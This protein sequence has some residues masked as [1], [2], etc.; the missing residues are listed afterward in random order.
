MILLSSL[1]VQLNWRKPP[2]QGGRLSNRC[3][4]SVLLFNHICFLQIQ[5]QTISFVCADLCI[6][7]CFLLII[8]TLVFQSNSHDIIDGDSETSE[9]S[10]MSDLSANNQPAQWSNSFLDTQIRSISK[11]EGTFLTTRQTLMIYLLRNYSCHDSSLWHFDH[12][13]YSSWCYS[14]FDRSWQH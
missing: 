7:L 1:A 11:L 12:F 13:L 4:V 2:N 14:R 9:A 3:L 10:D 5:I 6:H 8:L